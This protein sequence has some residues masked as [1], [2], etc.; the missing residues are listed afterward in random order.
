MKSA[1]G[2]RYLIWIEDV[3][4]DK[5]T[6]TKLHFLQMVNEL[7]AS[8]VD[9]AG[10][11]QVFSNMKKNPGLAAHISPSEIRQGN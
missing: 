3:A 10:Y 8:M 6:L 7:T 4:Y 1:S 5:L 11:Y 9:K 2:L